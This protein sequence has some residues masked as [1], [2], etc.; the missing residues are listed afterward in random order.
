MF[1]EFRNKAGKG[2]IWRVAVV[3]VAV[4]VLMCA[5]GC[6]VK[7]QQP[8]PEAGQP[9]I[10][11]E[12]GETKEKVTLYFG[13][14]QAMYLIP[15]EREVVKGSK[16]LE[17][18]IIEELTKG[19]KNPDAVKIMPQDAKLLSVSVVNGVAYLNFSKEFQTKHVG[20]SAGESMTLYSIINSLAK[21]TGIEKVQFLLEGENREA[22]LGHIDT[23]RPI[24]PDWKLV[25]E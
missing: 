14:K 18:V 21:L 12:P 13:D 6:R 11:S 1:H 22:I 2:F 10:S 25:K 17:T 7:T 4:L 8:V 15:E 3:A 19:P 5:G 24:A 9:E 16:S 23:T 20:G